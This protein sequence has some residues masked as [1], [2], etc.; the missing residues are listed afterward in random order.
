MKNYKCVCE[1]QLLVLEL[2]GTLFFVIEEFCYSF[3]ARTVPPENVQS[4]S[5]R[6]R[7]GHCPPDMATCETDSLSLEGLNWNFLHEY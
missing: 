2:D 7:E 5:P 4:K 3:N 6:L 1:R